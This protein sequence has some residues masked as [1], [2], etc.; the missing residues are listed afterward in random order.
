MQPPGEVNAVVV[1][2][3]VDVGYV[4]SVVVVMGQVGLPSPGVVVEEYPGLAPDGV[5]VTV[6]DDS[7]PGAGTGCAFC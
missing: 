4:K 7:L 3:V 2:V 5:G 6:D 1:V